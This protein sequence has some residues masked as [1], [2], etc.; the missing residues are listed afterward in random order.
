MLIGCTS[1]VFLFWRSCVTNRPL[2]LRM[3]PKMDE[4]AYVRCDASASIVV[5]VADGPREIYA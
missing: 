1:F 5:A 3:K 2:G 4:C